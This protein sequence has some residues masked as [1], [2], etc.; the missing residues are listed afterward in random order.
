MEQETKP[1]APITISGAI[2]IPYR[3]YAGAIASR[4]FIEL[5]NNKR[6]MGTICLQCNRV[7]VPPRSTC[8][9]CFN[10]LDEWVELNGRGT[11]QSYTV[12]HYS[13]PVHPLSSPFIYGVILLDGADTG[14]VHFLEEVEPEELK[15]GMRLIPVF[16]DQRDGDILDIRYF[17]P[18]HE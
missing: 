7:Y 10:K 12:V 13:L 15:I 5:R 3:Y 8:F 16:K 14:L 4:F 1:K 6:I 2:I 17:K 11:L 18:L 9:R